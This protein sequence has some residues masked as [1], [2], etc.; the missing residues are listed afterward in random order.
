M[1]APRSLWLSALATASLGIVCLAA[2]AQAQI[3][4]E[5]V[6][7]IAPFV[8]DPNPLWRSPALIGMG[9]LVLGDDRNNRLTMWNFARNPVG[10]FDADSTSTLE[11]RPGMGSAYADRLSP[12][13]EPRLA[14]Q[15]LD[16]RQSRLGY[17]VWRRT[18]S[19][20]A[21]GFYGDI[22][23]THVA[24]P[25]SETTALDHGVVEPGGFVAV[26]GRFPLF[27][28]ERTQFSA[29]AGYIRG[30]AKNQYSLLYE[31]PT[32]QYIGRGADNISSPDLFTPITA[33]NTY[34]DA[35]LGMS[36][37]FGPW[38]TSALGLDYLEQR[39]EYS[40]E[41]SRHS[42]TGGET[43]PYG[44]GQA[45]VMG[46]IGPNFQWIADGHGWQVSNED[47]WAFTLSAGIIEPPLSGRGLAFQRYEEGSQLRTRGRYLLG[48]F[49]LG[50]QVNTYYQ[51]V[52]ITAPD[53]GDLSSFNYFLNTIPQ[54]QNSDSLVIPD[55]ISSDQTD[56]RNVDWGL[57][58][59]YRLKHDRGRVG[60][61]YHWLRAHTDQ[62][63]AGSRSLNSWDVRTGLEYRLAPM[64]LGRAG[65]VYRGWDADELTKQNQYVTST[66]TAGLGVAPPSARWG[67]DVGYAYEW[68]APDYDDPYG[69]AGHRQQLALQ[70]NWKL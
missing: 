20:N 25:Y 34:L 64:L 33:K 14:R 69:L 52:R 58:G 35:G 65:Y 50:G 23:G 4:L 43:R 68:G 24:T 53:A 57:G 6:S 63:L 55:S 36:Y 28:P 32:G 19:G 13:E 12:A 51:R 70:L 46:N 3:G 31:N 45:T 21:Y 15:T 67:V 60:L 47:H 5:P 11:V 54:R 2:T 40:N 8:S 16:G 1:S 37:R 38:L 17:E 62:V 29:R 39:I 22:T 48:Q 59:F 26:N 61:E 27:H 56:R 49:E 7:A 66:I 9:Q 18:H 10:I 30:T 41:G 44:L 42:S